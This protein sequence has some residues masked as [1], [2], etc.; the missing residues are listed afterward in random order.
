MKFIKSEHYFLVKTNNIDTDE[1]NQYKFESIDIVEMF[2]ERK[3]VD[4]INGEGHIVQYSEVVDS[5]Q[6]VTDYE[7]NW[8]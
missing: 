2:I 6:E 8:D 7:L 4:D 1:Y 3:I 5:I